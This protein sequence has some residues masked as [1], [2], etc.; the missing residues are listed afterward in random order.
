MAYTHSYTHLY[1]HIHT[2]HARTHSQIDRQTDAYTQ[3]TQTHRCIV[4][5]R[6]TSTYTTHTDNRET[7]RQM[8]THKDKKKNP[9]H[10]KAGCTELHHRERRKAANVLPEIMHSSTPPKLGTVDLG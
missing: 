10:L 9:K 4:T 6:H 8:H 3:H 2:T 5:H 7:D 1:L